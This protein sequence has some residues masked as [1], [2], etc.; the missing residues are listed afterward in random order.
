MGGIEPLAVK[1]NAFNARKYLQFSEK[2]Q[3]S[4]ILEENKPILQLN[5][6]SDSLEEVARER[7]TPAISKRKRDRT[8]SLSENILFFFQLS[9]TIR[10]NKI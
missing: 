7:R 1:K 3:F 4:K 9:V 8:N 6:I 10:G 2:L 5:R